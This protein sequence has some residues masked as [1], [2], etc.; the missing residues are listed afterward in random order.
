[1]LREHTWLPFDSLHFDLFSQDRE[2]THFHRHM[3]GKLFGVVSGR[4]PFQ[5]KALFLNLDAEPAHPDAP[6]QLPL[7][8]RFQ[9]LRLPESRAIVAHLVLPVL[10]TSIPGQTATFLPPSRRAWCGS[11]TLRGSHQLGAVRE[12]AVLLLLLVFHVLHGAA[13][14]LGRAD[15]HGVVTAL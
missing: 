14:G 10:A 8:E 9:L 11:P 5:D 12:G 13:A 1:M 4:A 3:L 2:C 7:H 6:Q 15:K